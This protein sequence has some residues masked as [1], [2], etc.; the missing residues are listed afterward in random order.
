MCALCNWSVDV[1]KRRLRN[2][3]AAFHFV[4]DTDDVN[5]NV[6]VVMGRKKKKS[7]ED[8]EWISLDFL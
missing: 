7:E 8:L 4:H 2:L 6:D 1:A 3:L 5:V